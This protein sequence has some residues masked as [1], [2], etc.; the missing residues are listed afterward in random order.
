MKTKLHGVLGAVAL[1]CISTFWLSTLVSEILLE[2]AHV[3]AVKN[4]I[5]SGMWLL[6]PVMAATGGS[7]FALAKGRSGRLISR[8]SLRMRWVAANGLLV[9]LP[10]AYMLAAWANAGHF[11]SGFYALQGL[12][13]LAG[14]VNIGLLVL[15]MRDGMQLSGA[16]KP[17]R[18]TP[19]HR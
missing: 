11:D 13:L 7:G 6:I 8:K 19:V 5:L 17:R 1:V 9:L 18:P 4:A 3:V 15:N 14:A 16:L 2:Q 10:S 12:E